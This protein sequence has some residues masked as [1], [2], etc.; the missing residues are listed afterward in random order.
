MGDLTF[1][2]SILKPKWIKKMFVHTFKNIYYYC[3]TLTLTALY[4]KI[5]YC[6]FKQWLHYGSHVASEN[7]KLINRA[8]DI[9]WPNPVRATEWLR[10]SHTIKD[11]V[12]TLSAF[13]SGV[14]SSPLRQQQGTFSKPFSTSVPSIEHPGYPLFIDVGKCKSRSPILS[15]QSF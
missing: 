1:F 12:F 9:R 11:A 4:D 6:M 15:F 7:V 5:W 2:K 3:F 10:C 13:P 14:H 8:T